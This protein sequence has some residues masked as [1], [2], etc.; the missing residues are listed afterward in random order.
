MLTPKPSSFSRFTIARR[1][2]LSQTKR[3]T[4][5]N[6][7]K[8]FTETKSQNKPDLGRNISALLGANYRVQNQPKR[9]KKSIQPTP[10]RCR[11]MSP[12]NRKACSITL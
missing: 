11:T 3:E 7:R 4:I 9:R 10:Q 12:K 8:F 1:A 2:L 5:E 6:V